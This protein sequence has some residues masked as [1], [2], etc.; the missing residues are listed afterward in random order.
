MKTTHIYLKLQLKKLL[1][2]IPKLLT[3]TIVLAFLAGTIAFC[4]S[5]LLYGQTPTGKINIAIVTE[6]DT[7][8]M[9]LAMQY[10]DSSESVHSFCEL[11]KTNKKDADRMLAHKK[12]AACVY[13]PKDFAKDV[14]TGKNTPAVIRFSEETGIEQLLFQELA[15]A[16]SRILNYA[17]ASIYSFSDVYDE[18]EFR[19][20]R[21]A[22][23]DYIN[24]N[25]LRTALVRSDLFQTE[26]VSSTG[27]L[28]VKE[29][30]TVTALILLLFFTGMSL[31]EF[32]MPEQGS[33]GRMLTLKGVSAP[34][35]T[36]CRLT[37]LFCFYLLMG[38]GVF[39]AGYFLKQVPLKLFMVLPYMALLAGSQTLFL[40]SLNGSAAAK[41]L[42]VFFYTL[43]SAFCAG[44]LIPSA[45]LPVCVTRTGTLFPA[46]YARQILSMPFTG[47]TDF[48]VCL[49]ALGCALVLL[50]LSASAA[51]RS[52]RR[53]S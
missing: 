48:S 51:I 25:T 31:G 26:T 6:D 10:L 45:F 34:I 33:L 30:Y 3:G 28:S 49:P 29:H 37:A 43:L 5:T 46:Y 13:F 14:V 40:Y 22:H 4:G 19:G 32:A 23:F 11:V 9:K 2:F 53:T 16:A 35:R 39:L 50:L 27:N 47:T 41:T 36:L 18:Y 52:E 24:Q 42:L 44:C 8:L 21:G 1:C 15:T 7:A 20:K 17:Q 12:V 38:G